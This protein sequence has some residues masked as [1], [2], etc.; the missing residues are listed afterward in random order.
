MQDIIDVGIKYTEKV[1]QLRDQG[2]DFELKKANPT[3]SGFDLQSTVEVTIK[4]N[5]RIAIP[6]GIHICLP[7]GWEAQVRGR[8]GL[9]LKNGVTVGNPPGTIDHLYRKE[10]GIILINHSDVPFDIKIG[11]KV[12]QLCFNRV[13]IIH[14]KEFDFDDTGRSGFGST[15]V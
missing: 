8:S 4:P 2:I 9:S 1:K 7:E 3:D 14:L 5:E 15:G 10:I 13:P 11:M 6:S 12:A